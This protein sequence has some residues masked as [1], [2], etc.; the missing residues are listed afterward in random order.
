MNTPKKVY[1][2]LLKLFPVKKVQD[3]FNVNENQSD[4]VVTVSE[5]NTIATMN[6]FCADHLS[7]T[8]QHIFLFTHDNAN[9]N[10]VTSADF[11]CATVIA[12]RPANTS[13]TFHM[14]FDVDY[15]LALTNPA[16]VEIIKYKWPVSV[17]VTSSYIIVHITVLERNPAGEFD[18]GR[19]IFVTDRSLKEEDILQQIRIA[20]Q[21]F[22]E[23]DKCDL[24]AGVKHLWANDV[25]DA[26][27]TRYKKANSVSSETMDENMTIKAD[28]ED[29][30]DELVLAPLQTTMFRF[31]QNVNNRYMDHVTIDPTN[32]VVRVTIYPDDQTQV[33]N[34]ID[35]ILQ[36]N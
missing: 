25:I 4:L 3:H 24:N 35:D 16:A 8:K 22:A 7:M 36:H 27:A 14:L 1:S 18:G 23:L 2:R 30:Y 15:E 26:R 32:G 12:E 31:M 11:D 13:K 5:G 6:V 21:G 34:V 28:L 10:A 19:R 9:F 20:L 17:K 29:V 33:Q